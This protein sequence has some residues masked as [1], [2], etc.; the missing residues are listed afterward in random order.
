M[1]VPRHIQRLC[2]QFVCQF[3]LLQICAPLLQSSLDTL[4]DLVDARAGRGT[5]FR[6]QIAQA[7]EQNGQAAFLAKITRLGLL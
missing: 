6:R 5:L 4:L 2:R 3:S 7:L 1:P